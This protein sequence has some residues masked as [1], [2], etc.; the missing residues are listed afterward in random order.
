MDPNREAFTATP[1]PRQEAECGVQPLHVGGH[2][3]ECYGGPRG[4]WSCSSTWVRI[5]RGRRRQ[6]QGQHPQCVQSGGQQQPKVKNNHHKTFPLNSV[7]SRPSIFS[8]LSDT[9]S[10]HSTYL[11]DINAY[12]KLIIIM[13]TLLSLSILILYLFILF[14]HHAYYLEI[15]PGKQQ[16]HT[17]GTIL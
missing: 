6:G 15:Y 14:I 5:C 17:N 10:N 16:E 8:R 11:V 9:L 13:L 2:P 3:G 12:S 1:T 7:I 4:Q